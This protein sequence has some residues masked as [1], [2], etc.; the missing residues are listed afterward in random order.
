[1]LERLLDR[2]YPPLATLV[3]LPLIV[4]ICLVVITGPTLAVRRELGR[5]GVRLLL[6][7]IGVRLRVRGLR[8]L[9]PGP[10][11]AVANHAS[12]LDGLVLTAALPRRY[13]FVVQDGAAAW[14][15]VGL[16]LRRMGV[17]F[18]NR[19]SARES[20][21][22]TRQLMRRLHHGE[23]LAIF[24]EGT[25]KPQPG[26]LPFKS[27]A[28]LMA[29]RE[30][31]PVVPVGIRGTRRLYGGGRRLPRWSTVDIEIGAALHADGI[32]REAALA[33]RERTRERV[34]ELSGEPELHLAQPTEHDAP[35]VVS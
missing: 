19:A 14:P 8:H 13:S 35:H 6:V 22:L 24:A 32:H 3:A 30:R 12:Y 27:G 20:A 28:F 4:L 23:P 34:R 7:A 26:L 17:I 33:L 1:M 18:V 21:R 11:I 9:P 31:V 10:N 16:T 15:L 25:F 5:L 29:A 2:L